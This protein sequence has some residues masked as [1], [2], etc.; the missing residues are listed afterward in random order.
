VKILNQR[1][2]K[3]IYQ[4]RRYTVEP[5]QGL[6]QEIFELERCW[7]RGHPHNRWLFA[8][9]GVAVQMH[10]YRAWRAGRSPWAIKQEVLGR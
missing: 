4:Q 7:M 6:L 2:N 5:R 8:A 1:K 3:K 10:Q 9:M